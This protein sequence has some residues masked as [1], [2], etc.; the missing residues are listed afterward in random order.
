MNK[1][2]LII[3][4]GWGRPIII[5]K[6]ATNGFRLISAGPGS[7]VGINNADIDTAITSNKGVDDRVLYL[8]SAT[9]SVD[10]NIPCDS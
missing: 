5:Q 4:D 10:V 1:V 2:L 8:N 6:H 7:G 3:L 9:P